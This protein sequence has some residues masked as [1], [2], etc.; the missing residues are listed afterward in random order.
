[1]KV[2][3]VEAALAYDMRVSLEGADAPA[4]CEVY[5]MSWDSFGKTPGEHWKFLDVCLSVDCTNAELNSRR[6]WAKGL[7]L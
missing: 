5:C 1:M 2:W 6:T 4:T 7:R 3:P